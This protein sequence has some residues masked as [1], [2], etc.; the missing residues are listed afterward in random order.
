MKDVACDNKWR[1]RLPAP[2]AGYFLAFD[3]DKETGKLYAASLNGEDI[4]IWPRKLF[5]DWL[6]KPRGTPE[7][8]TMA[9]HMRIA[10]QFYGNEHEIDRQGRFV[11]ARNVREALRDA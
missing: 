2:Y 5:F 8:A 7:E 1:L 3:P 10:L 6:D 4:L 11:L 9:R